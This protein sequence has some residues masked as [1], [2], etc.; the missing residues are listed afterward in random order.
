MTLH[1]VEIFEAAKALVVHHFGRSDEND[2]LQLVAGG[3]GRADKH[4]ALIDTVGVVDR[5]QSAGLQD[6]AVVDISGGASV[7]AEILDRDQGIAV[8]GAFEAIQAY[9]CMIS[10]IHILLNNYSASIPKRA[11]SPP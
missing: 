11:K 3:T 9:D 5:H 2:V 6:V 1:V 4:F 10:H 8:A 7:C